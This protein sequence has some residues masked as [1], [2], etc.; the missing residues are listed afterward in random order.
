MPLKEKA[1]ESIKKQQNTKLPYWRR[2][3]EDLQR[4]ISIGNFHDYKKIDG[5]NWVTLKAKN[6]KVY[7]TW[8]FEDPK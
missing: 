8:I 1:I 4:G 3:M 5:K 7:G 2:Q 6:E